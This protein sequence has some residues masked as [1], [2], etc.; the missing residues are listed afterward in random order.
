MKTSMKGQVKNIGLL[1]I[2]MR[3]L[4]NLGQADPAR[5]VCQL[6]MSDPLYHLATLPHNLIK[7]KL[8][9]LI[10]WTFKM[11]DSPY[12]ACYE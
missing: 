2:L 1:T 9:N 3:Y 5:P 7:E 8:I 12:L 6:K 10:E 11:E 4:I